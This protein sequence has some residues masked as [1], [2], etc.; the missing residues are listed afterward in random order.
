MTADQALLT[1]IEHYRAGHWAQAEHLCRRVLS[2]EP[3]HADA[4][5]ILGAVAHRIGKS[6][7]ALDLVSRAVALRPNADAYRN[8][9]GSIHHAMGHPE[10]AAI[11]H[12]W[13][14]ALNPQNAEAQSNLGNELREIG[15]YEAAAASCRAALDLQP[16]YAEAHNNLATALRDLGRLEEAAATYRRAIECKPDYAAAYSNLAATLADLDQLEPAKAACHAALALNPALAHAHNNLGNLLCREGKN[17]EAIAAF[18]KAVE[19]SPQWALPYNNLA[20]ALIDTRRC[21]AAVD[22]LRTAIALQPQFPDAHLNLGNAL[23]DLGRH[24]E[25]I[26]SFTTALGL[27][28][29]F[30]DAHSN[31]GNAL[32]DQGMLDDAIASYRRAL[33]LAPNNAPIQ[34]NLIFALHFHPR[35]TEAAIAT[36]Q[37]RWNERH[38][39]PLAPS[40]RRHGNDPS[41]ER[42]LRVGYVSPDFR[43]H[44]LAYF[45]APLLRAHDLGCVEVF[46]Y[47]SARLPD[48]TTAEFRGWADEWREVLRLSDSELAELICEDRIDILIDLSLHTAHHRLLTFARKPA[49]VQVSWLA[50]PGDAGLEAM[51]YYFTDPHGT[52]GARAFRL[53]VSWCCFEARGDYPEVGERQ[54]HVT[55][56]SLNNLCKVNDGV[57][58]CW[59]GILREVTDSKLLLHAHEGRGRQWVRQVLAAEGVAES[60]V[61]F[62]PFLR[63]AGHLQLYRDIDIA[64]DP[65]PCNGLTTSCTA[66]WMGVPVVSLRNESEVSRAGWSLLSNLGLPELAASSPEEYAGIAATLAKDRARLTELRRT[67]RARMQTSPLMDAERFARDIETAYR[68]MWRQWSDNV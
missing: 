59:A 20:T 58:R 48:G 53:P 4:L 1:A 39:A 41:T 2:A 54:G 32:K 43:E 44:S 52:G 10:R 9:L 50:Y 63:R 7:L 5:H 65:F 19:L 13:A 3:D 33:A 17:E 56:G 67:M 30:A 25:A 64:L 40:R 68:T 35:I 55:F 26:A 28:P 46:C 6:A 45:L 12:R 31:M 21:Q 42:R 15:Q 62:A 8:T 16:D 27:K 47:S 66:L 57:L 38:T 36:E 23:M 22:T 49:P 37:A 11:E 18:A 14:V 29:A 24:E 61:E 51:D 60:R 34:S